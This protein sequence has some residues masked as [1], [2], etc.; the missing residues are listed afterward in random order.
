MLRRSNPNQIYLED[1]KLQFGGKLRADNRWVILSKHMPW[2]KIDEIYAR[3]F[4]PDSGVEA[5][6]SRI[7]FGS[8]YAKEQEEWTDRETLQNI[9]ENPYLQYFLG[10]SEFQN[11]A[12]FEASM[13]VHFRKRFPVEVVNE[14]NELIF[15]SIARG[16]M[17]DKKTPN[18]P[19]VTSTESS[20][21]NSPSNN[22]EA[23]PVS[24]SPAN[25]D[26]T[27]SSGPLVNGEISPSG[28][29][30]DEGAAAPKSEH[31]DSGQVN[32]NNEQSVS[33]EAPAVSSDNVICILSKPA[34]SE[35]KGKLILDATCAPADIRY[36]TDLSLLNEARENTEA[37]LDIL[38]P[39]QPLSRAQRR[40]QERDRK[41][42][43]QGFLSIT[44]QKRPG[45][46]KVRAAINMQLKYL[47]KNIE[48]IGSLMLKHGMGELE[49]KH[50]QRII[51]ICELYR[52]QLYM[53]QNKIH[54]CE[55]R[56]VSLRQPH[57]R[58]IVR[59]K[60]GVP[61]E[62]GQKIAL[63]V[64]DGYTFID[65]QSFDSF[66]E[67]V[68]LI[69]CVERYKE[70]FGFYPEA[71]L[72]DQIYRTRENRVFCKK[73]GIRLSGPK[74]G[75]PNI[76]E[77]EDKDRQAYQDSCE[78][79]TIES[80]IG[81]SKRRFGLDLIMCYLPETAL[82]EA[83]LQIMC[84]NFSVWLRN[85]FL[86]FLNPFL[87]RILSVFQFLLTYPSLRGAQRQSKLV[88]QGCFVFLHSQ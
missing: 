10:F 25:V 66:N 15:I 43:R 12:P 26:T 35:N 16:A 59:S 36:P 57:I 68:Y 50:F 34:A 6:S 87:Q 77:K 48:A 24:Q 81:I 14:I 30:H 18:Q 42:A 22:E 84:T 47:R 85:L 37:I 72:A 71:V 55:N 17:E 62:F 4:S 49:E 78:R 83:A 32:S 23:A 2:D 86:L 75:R 56:I 5:I 3:N 79:N 44:K 33:I 73:Y 51:T 65:K 64:V 9:M 39:L 76:Q 8:I 40:K 63:C 19:S 82:T 20:S 13:M 60:A 88:N 46:R 67:G 54:K 38:Q 69:E 29:P 21:A 1:F 52:Q 45:S 41:K 28:A 7:A 74:L 70:R 80:R 31:S 11:K 58:P 53:L 27:S 61:C